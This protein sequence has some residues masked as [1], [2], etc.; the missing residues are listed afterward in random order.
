MGL[1]SGSKDTVNVAR[2]HEFMDRERLAAVVARSGQNFTYLNDCLWYPPSTY[3]NAGATVTPYDA[4]N[5]E[6][7]R[8][9]GGTCYAYGLMLAYNQFSSST[10][11]QKSGQGGGLGEIET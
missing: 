7:P 5:L 3:G 8:A 6:V 4:N 10:T 2:L 9:M 1:G 11:L